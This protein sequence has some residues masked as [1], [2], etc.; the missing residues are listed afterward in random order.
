MWLE[1]NTTAKLQKSIF[2]NTPHHMP[3]SNLA[4]IS[5][6]VIGVKL[7]ISRPR[8]AKSARTCCGTSRELRGGAM[9]SSERGAAVSNL[10]RRSYRGEG[11][12]HDARSQ[13]GWAS[14]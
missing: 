5:S 11:T 14:L 4:I 9:E 10:H 7:S 8:A 12:Y 2:F 1:Q 3:Q 6:F 13:R